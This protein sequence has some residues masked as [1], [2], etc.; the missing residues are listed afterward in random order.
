MPLFSLNLVFVLGYIV[1]F[2]RM[3]LFMLTSDRFAIVV[4]K[5]VNTYF[6]NFPVLILAMINIG[7]YIPH[8]QKLFGILFRV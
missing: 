8:K 6:K 5:R 2:H 1:I 3:L 7:R 4:F